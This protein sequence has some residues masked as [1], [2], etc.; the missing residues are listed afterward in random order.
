MKGSLRSKY[1]QQPILLRRET[2]EQRRDHRRIHLDLPEH[3][4]DAR[5]EDKEVKIL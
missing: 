4:V 3:P 5:G 1:Y 2:P